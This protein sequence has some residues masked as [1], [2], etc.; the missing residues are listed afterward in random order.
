MTDRKTHAANQ[1]QTETAVWD[2]IGK[3]STT[4]YKDKGEQIADLDALASAISEARTA[5]AIHKAFCHGHF[6]GSR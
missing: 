2:L 5:R 1:D 4:G 6:Q 3:L